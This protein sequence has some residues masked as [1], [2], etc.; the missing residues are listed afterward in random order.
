MRKAPWMIIRCVSSRASETREKKTFP[1]I[2]VARQG[3]L[4]KHKKNSRS[5]SGDFVW[6]P[7]KESEA[8]LGNAIFRASEHHNET[9]MTICH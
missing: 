8:S 6:K 7:K 3:E 4:R 2:S 9:S 5:E 1:L